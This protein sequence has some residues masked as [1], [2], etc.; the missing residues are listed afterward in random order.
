MSGSADILS[1][2]VSILILKLW[3]IVYFTSPE[4]VQQRAY[5]AHTI[6]RVEMEFKYM[7]SHRLLA[8]CRLLLTHNKFRK[9]TLT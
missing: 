1:D 9:G 8:Q 5:L 6:P 3:N 7:V 4:N 2:I